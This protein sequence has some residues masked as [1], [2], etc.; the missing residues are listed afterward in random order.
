MRERLQAERKK[1]L[2]R[3]QRL[4]LLTVGAAIV[5][6]AV[7]VGLIVWLA[8]SSGDAKTGPSPAAAN[9]QGGLTLQAPDTFAAGD[10]KDV[11]LGELPE[12][13]EPQNPTPLPPEAEAAPEGE[14]A[15]VVIYA[16]ANCVHCAEFDKA[17]RADLEKALSGG[18]ITLEYRLVNYL[19]YTSSNNYSSRAAS[20]TACVAEQNPGAYLPFLSSIYDAYGS[21]PSDDEL[22]QMAHQEGADISSCVNDGTYD[23]FVQYTSAMGMAAP[24]HGTPSVWVQGQSWAESGMEFD[25]FL[26]QG[27]A[28]K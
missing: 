18:D 14:P 20:A 26:K 7:V 21:E 6:G 4:K 22:I 23:A 24:V 16:D 28:A 3:K 17:Y 15:R 5:A 19:D 27:L 13:A 1:E 25:Q 2:A 10:L 11:D 12:P 8:V 9:Q